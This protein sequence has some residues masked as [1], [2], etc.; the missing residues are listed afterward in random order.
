MRRLIP[1][2]EQFQHY[3]EGVQESFWGDLYQRTRLA[4]EK[5]FGGGIAAGARSSPG[6]E[7]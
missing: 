7:G 5:F 1:I 4:W 3:L 2:T 6:R